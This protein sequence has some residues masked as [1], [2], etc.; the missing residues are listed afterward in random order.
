MTRLADEDAELTAV[1][2]AH[3]NLFAKPIP[4][5]VREALVG[6]VFALRR[7]LPGDRVLS[8]EA[9][10]RLALKATERLWKQVIHWSRPAEGD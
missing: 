8:D 2:A 9:A 5:T 1:V 4:K 6:A 10:A 7:E 3:L